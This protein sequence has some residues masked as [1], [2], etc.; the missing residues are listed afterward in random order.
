MRPFTTPL[1]I[2]EIFHSN[3]PEENQCAHI[4]TSYLH[5]QKGNPEVTVVIPA[6]NEEHN[7]LKTL[8]TLVN[9]QS[10]YNIEIIVVNNN[11]NDRTEEIVKKAGIVCI[12][13][14][15]PGITAARN[16]GLKAAKG[17]YILSADADTFYPINW[18]EEMVRP[19]TENSEIALVYGNFSFIPT[20]GTPRWI[21]FFYEYLADLLRWYNKTFKEEAVNVYGFNSGFKK[22]QGLAVNGYE[23]PLGTN[24]DGWLALKLREKKFGKLYQVNN[25]KALVWTSDRRIQLDGGL[26]KGIIKRI[27]RLIGFTSETRNDL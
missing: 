1:Y 19:M 12:L 26:V 20:V 9:N 23:H 27:K 8:S 4:N 3:K 2:T 13:E 5:L 14:K 21:Y 6:Y 17:K 10:K 18:I 25:R 16:A 11:S 15:V 7:I 24:E 22:D